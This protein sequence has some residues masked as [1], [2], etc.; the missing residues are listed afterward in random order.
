MKV[1]VEDPRTTI[2]TAFKLVD[3]LELSWI[4]V[5]NGALTAKAPYYAMQLF[6]Q[7]FGSI[8]VSSQTKSP[9]YEARSLGWVDAVAFVPYLETVSS[10]SPR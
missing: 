5:R 3:A 2:A 7:H 8:V 10:V 9:G 6:T 1:I 4:G